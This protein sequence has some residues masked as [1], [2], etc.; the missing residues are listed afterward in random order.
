MPVK[1][2]GNNDE[3]ENRNLPR[4]NAAYFP[5][6][7]E[8]AI[9][10]QRLHKTRKEALERYFKQRGTNLTNGIRQVLYEWM[11]EAGIR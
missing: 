6:D 7:D 2:K 10:S 4:D 1:N 3:Y 8:W 11:D 5:L 9:V